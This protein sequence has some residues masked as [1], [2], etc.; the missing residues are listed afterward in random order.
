[1]NLERRLE[2]IKDLF[3]RILGKELKALFL[4]GSAARGEYKPG[5]SDLNLLAIMSKV[6]RAALI[7]AGSAQRKAGRKIRLLCFTEEYFKTSLDTYPIEI[8]DLKLHHRKLAGDF[9]FTEL[10]TEKE[11]LRLQVERELKGKSYL[12]RQAVIGYGCEEKEMMRLAAD[13]LSAILAVM[14]GALYLLDKEIPVKRGELIEGICQAY[15]LDAKI[16]ADLQAL[17]SAGRL[18]RVRKAEDFYFGLIEALEM[19]AGKVDAMGAGK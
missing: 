4:Y 1:M 14:Q 8:L 11:F 2:K 7:K 10:A 13:H 15:G 6:D 16:K 3:Q 12:M 5:R 17:Q 19:M 18:S 9:N